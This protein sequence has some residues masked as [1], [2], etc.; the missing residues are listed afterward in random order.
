MFC[1]IFVLFPLM[2]I[3]ACNK[4]ILM[5]KVPCKKRC[6]TK[7]PWVRFLKMFFILQSLMALQATTEVEPQQ[8]IFWCFNLI[9]SINGYVKHVVAKFHI[10]RYY[11]KSNEYFFYK[12]YNRGNG[13]EGRGEMVPISVYEIIFKAK[14]LLSSWLWFEM[15][16]K[17]Y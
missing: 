14:L 13:C 17:M 6:K 9:R 8:K 7:L 2:L 16:A 11:H 1:E 10:F 3:A 12:R 15:M 4:M 5:L